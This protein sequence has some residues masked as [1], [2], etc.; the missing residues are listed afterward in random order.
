MSADPQTPTR[1]HD[2][3]AIRVLAIGS[4]I[5]YHVA[6]FY[7]GGDGWD[8]HVKSQYLTDW[9]QP[10]M[11]LMNRWRMELLFLVSG[12]ALSLLL[13]KD[14]SLG[15]LAQV[16]SARLL[17]PLIFGMAVVIPIQP[18]CQMLS[19]HA[20]KPG[21]WKFLL[22]Y[23][24]G[25]G[26]A[27][28][29]YGGAEHGWTWNHLWYLAY[30]WVYT[31]L[32]LPIA[33]LL[34]TAP[35][36]RLRA[37]VLKLRGTALMLLPAIPFVIYAWTL[38]GRFPETHDLIHDG[39]MHPVYFTI[40][41]YGYWIG[42]D[43]GLWAEL[44]QRRW[45]H[46]GFAALLFACYFTTLK[47][48]DDD[49][50]QWQLQIIRTLRWTYMW[51]ALCAVLGWSHALLNRPFRWLPYASEAV[52]PWYVLHQSLI[53]GLG[54]SL[55]T[56]ALGPVIEPVLLLSGTVAGCALLHHFVIR[57]VNFLRPLFGLK[58]RISPRR[59]QQPSTV[60]LEGR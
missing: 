14:A 26:F 36:R 58:M 59:A 19:H 43:R 29:A 57:R 46:L 60:I 7:V 25:K 38:Q 2:I 8:Y 45:T 41:V 32:M 1:R 6:M 54:Y 11:L 15:R 34:A 5:L 53:V 56:Y 37:P 28:G 35:G 50:P 21:F 22:R 23:W 3:D 10:P 27:P 40:F 52:Y 17:I 9:L 30:L 42:A 39:F 4:L 44:T 47:I 12:V 13:G 55:S 18:Y 16:R 51:I 49:L 20:I 31:M 33:W 48:T 24:S